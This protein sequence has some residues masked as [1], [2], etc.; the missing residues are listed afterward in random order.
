MTSVIGSVVGA[1]PRRLHAET[2]GE[3]RDQL[4]I[5]DTYT[6]MVNGEP[7]DDNTLLDEENFVSF[8]PAVKGG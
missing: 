4:A 8:S 1:T 6:A 5:A 7:A 3:V 2:V